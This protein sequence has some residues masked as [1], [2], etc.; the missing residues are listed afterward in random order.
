MEENAVWISTFI[1]TRVQT[2][3]EHACWGWY[4]YIEW[5]GEQWYWDWCRQECGC[6]SWACKGGWKSS[7][8]YD[9]GKY[10]WQKNA[11]EG[12]RSC[13][14]P[15]RGWVGYYWRGSK[16]AFSE[17]YRKRHCWWFTKPWSRKTI[18]SAY[19][20]KAERTTKGGQCEASIWC[21]NCWSLLTIVASRSCKDEVLL[22]IQTEANA[23]KWWDSW[24]TIRPGCTD[25]HCICCYVTP[26]K[27]DG[28]RK[29]AMR[30]SGWKASDNWL[31]GIHHI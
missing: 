7:G 23:L 10:W 13:G 2:C 6:W 8:K 22:W 11:D 21:R 16:I 18:W 31:L 4:E 30:S 5:G 26:L 15:W 17:I 12:K 28:K 20:E 25:R 24:G 3:Q 19:Q 14:G 1:E 9:D 29:D 27:S